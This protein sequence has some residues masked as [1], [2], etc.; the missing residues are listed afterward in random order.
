MDFLKQLESFPEQIRRKDSFSPGS[1]F[2][3]VVISGMGGSG[4]VGRIFSELYHETPVEVVSDY[5]IP[6]YVDK[7]T[8]FLAI[9]YSGNTEET[10]TAVKSAISRGAQTVAI[11]SGGELGKLVDKCVKVPQGLQPRNALGYM[12]SPLIRS[13]IHPDENDIEEA[14]SLLQRLEKNSEFLEKIA[15]EIYEQELIPW[16]IGY[17]PYVWT[18]YRWKTQFNENSKILAV[19][20]NL[21]ELD[22][23]E[24][25]PMKLSYGI[26]RFFFLTL[27]E[28]ENPRNAKRME[29]TA[30]VTGIR[31]R[32]VPSSGKTKL[33]RILYMIHCGDYISYYIAKKRNM[34]PMDVSLIE[35][36]KKKLS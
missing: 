31:T 27:G 36:L 3:N 8:L 10:L 24:I 29:V 5:G 6:D 12:I 4:V 2:T 32:N 11:T 14:A 23:N 30:S 16:I 22:H 21:P 35:E 19:H 33:Q 34:D 25:M 17:N 13:L 26:G 1:E 9:S 18:S 28:P 20:S 7:K 15:D